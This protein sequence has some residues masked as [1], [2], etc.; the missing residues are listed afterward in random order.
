MDKSQLTST[1]SILSLEDF[2]KSQ[3]HYDDKEESLEE[4]FSPLGFNL[5]SVKSINSSWYELRGLRVVGSLLKS[6]EK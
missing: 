2:T 3:S 6:K 1:C 5:F 4:S